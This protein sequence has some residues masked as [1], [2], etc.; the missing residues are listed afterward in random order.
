MRHLLIL[1]V[2]LYTLAGCAG[3]QDWSGLVVDAI[4]SIKQ[5]ECGQKTQ[6]SKQLQKGDDVEIVALV[7]IRPICK[8]K[9]KE[10]VDD[11]RAG[12]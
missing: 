3:Q 8:D 9:D 6:W 10:G 7:E 2:A 1:I 4:P 12:Q 5:G 11:G